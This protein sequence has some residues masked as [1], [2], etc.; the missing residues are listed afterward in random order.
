[1]VSRDYF[2]ETLDFLRHK[3]QELDEEKER[4]QLLISKLG[5]DLSCRNGEIDRLTKEQS[6]RNDEI[7]R[8]T[9]E[10]SKLQKELSKLQKELVLAEHE[11]TRKDG[12]IGRLQG[13]IQ[14]ISGSLTWRMGQALG[15]G[16]YGT[17]AGK[18]IER[19]ATR[20]LDRAEDRRQPA[21][22]RRSEEQR[23][24]RL[25]ILRAIL[26]DF[27]DRKGVIVFPP[28][29][30]WNIPLFQRP[31]QMAL[32]LARQGYLFFYCTGKGGFDTL[33]GFQQLEER[34][35]LTDQYGL[36]LDVLDGFIFDLYSTQ[37]SQEA[38]FAHSL[39]GRGNI[40][41]YEY[42]DHIHEDISGPKT[43][44]L[45]SRHRNLKPDVIF[46]SARDLYD[47]MVVR[48]GGDTVYYL[49]NGVDYNHFHIARTP[50]DIPS[51]M[52]SIVEKKRQI[53]GYYGALANWLDY[54]LI[55]KIARLRPELEVVLIGWDYDGSINRL[56]SLGNIHYLGTKHYSVLPRY[57]V[58]FD[59]AIIPFVEGDIADSTSPLKL[60]EYMA[61]GKPIVTTNMK[62]C[63]RY[64]SVLAAGD[65]EEFLML[66]DRALALT[67]DKEYLDTL[68]REALANTWEARAQ[69]Y[70]GAITSVLSKRKT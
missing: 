18:L 4:M 33:E 69:T 8:L 43:S 51:D 1:M 55:N 59:V 46:A 34:C 3:I 37:Q 40:L 27:E 68:D 6:D 50:G 2:S 31:Q 7:D 5:S 26:R 35:F 58:W 67:F 36:I 30:D 14:V 60:F 39:K 24:R 12:E 28:T 49:P 63:K 9:K 57:A 17:T 10:L 44:F 52:E 25:E 16:I 19:V 62:E 61:L 70:D 32:H 38:H 29:V 66:V 64:E 45:S 41:V 54:E 65:H 48:F 13:H 53:V 11:L 20:L 47:E 42:V 21:S 15:K 23:R 22:R 56:E